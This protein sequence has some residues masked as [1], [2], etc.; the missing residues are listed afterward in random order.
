[1]QFT[2]PLTD[3]KI[4]IGQSPDAKHRGFSRGRY[5]TIP[6]HDLTGIKVDTRSLYSAWRNS[7]DVFACVREVRQSVGIGG[8]YF[9]DPKDPKKEKEAD[10]KLVDQFMSIV[11]YNAV[12]LRQFKDRVM[13]PRLI[14]ANT[15]IEK[16][17]NPF[18]QLIGLKVL[19]PRTMSVVSDE[20]GRVLKYI[21]TLPD[22]AEKQVDPVVFEPQDIIH[23]KLG[24]D[25]N[26]EV[27]GF[28]PMETVLW[29]VRTDLSAMVSN[30]FFFEND[31]AP[32]MWYI[33]N[34]D[35]D[36][37][38]ADRAIETI[39][40]QFKGAS[41]RHK[42]AVLQ[43]IKDIKTVRLSNKDMEF[44]LGRKYATEKVCA[45][46]GVPKV[47]LGYTEGVNYTNH[48]GQLQMFHDGTA[49]EHEEAFIE[50]LMGEVM[51][52]LGE[53]AEKRIAIGA[54]EPMF[55]SQG[56]L[57]ERA[58]RAREAG[59]VTVDGGRKIVGLEPIDEAV[60]GDMGKQIILG[61]GNMATLLTDVG[62]D[63]FDPNTEL[64]DFREKI[65]RYAKQNQ[66]VQ[67]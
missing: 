32:S 53:G 35:M 59:L 11:T 58:A 66:T 21:Q 33:L 8:F 48:E 9:Y 27:F 10:Q 18:G 13:E 61:S 34:D 16:V 44:L 31:A 63:P 55:E 52:E 47:L 25:P 1:M 40:K 23:W 37:D 7:G 5:S 14:A 29:E 4:A 60:H 51:P 20:H 49:V 15:Y 39:K 3:I 2:I 62:L 65:T 6:G 50:M 26:A 28:A 38:Q 42:S 46:F 54:K 67:A 36:N 19:D 24:S 12:S 17:R 45:A 57:W 43:N 30:Y 22:S 41:K 64:N 56:V